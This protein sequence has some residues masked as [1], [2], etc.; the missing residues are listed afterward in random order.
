M[1]YTVYVETEDGNT[2][3]LNGSFSTRKEAEEES[4]DIMWGSP[5]RSY[6]G[7]SKIKNSWVEED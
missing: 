1:S 5:E 3:S 4:N 7:D 6:L 2:Y